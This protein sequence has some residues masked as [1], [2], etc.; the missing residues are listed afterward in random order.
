MLSLNL[1]PARATSNLNLTSPRNTGRGKSLDNVGVVGEAIYTGGQIEVEGQV[2]VALTQAPLLMDFA[3]DQLNRPQV[4]WQV[5]G[6][7]SFIYFYNGLLSGYE[8]LNVGN[9]K[10]II[11]HNDYMYLGNNTIV[12]YIRS[13]NIYCRLQSDRFTVEYLWYSGGFTSI[14]KMGQSAYNNTIQVVVK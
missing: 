2:I 8:T 7:D 5:L 1:N 11:I 9:V 3:Y 4:V 10:S 6:G 12:A 13:G 14:L